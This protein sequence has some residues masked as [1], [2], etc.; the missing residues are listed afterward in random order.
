MTVFTPWQTFCQ[1]VGSAAGALTGLQFVAIALI[2]DV[3]MKGNEDGV[4][5]FSGPTIVHFVTALLLAASVVMPWQ[6]YTGPATVWTITGGCGLVFLAAITYRMRKQTAYRPVF[7]DWLFHSLLP[8]SAYT[9]LTA[10]GLCLKSHAGGALFGIA[11][12][13]L[14]LLVVGIHNSWDN[15]TFLITMRRQQANTAKSASTPQ[16]Q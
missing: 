13:S 14:L 6:G 7:E 3:P 11:T 5:A 4:E 10:S 12:V 1:I 15:L 8:F 16:A 9:G 2:A